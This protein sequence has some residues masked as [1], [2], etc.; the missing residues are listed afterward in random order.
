M[1]LLTIWMYKFPNLKM[2][3]SWLKVFNYFLKFNKGQNTTP[4]TPRFKTNVFCCTLTQQ[5]VNKSIRIFLF[6][7]VSW[8]LNTF[9]LQFPVSLKKKLLVMKLGVFKWFK[10]MSG[11]F[12]LVLPKAKKEKWGHSKN[13]IISKTAIFKVLKKNWTTSQ[14]NNYTKI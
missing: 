13:A 11:L 9:L 12:Y 8:F 4:T 5:H 6:V 14:G 2:L 7:P 3:I 10:R 1:V